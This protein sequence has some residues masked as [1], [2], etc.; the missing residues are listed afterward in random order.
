[1][2]TSGNSQ[3][4]MFCT[5]AHSRIFKRTVKDVLS[6]IPSAEN[7]DKTSWEDIKEHELYSKPINKAHTRAIRHTE[8]GLRSVD[9]H[10]LRIDA[11]LRM[12]LNR[13]ILNGK[14]GL[15][16]KKVHDILDETFFE[17][18]FWTLWSINFFLQPWHS[19]TEF[20]RLLQK[21]LPEMSTHK[22]VR[23]LDRTPFTLYES[24]IIPVTR[25]L[26]DQRVDFRFHAMVTDLKSYSASDPTTISEIVM[27]E[28]GKEMLITVNP[29]DI[30]IVTLGSLSTGM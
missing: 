20:Y 5:Q 18:D 12:D 28:N 13:F 22:D 23:E 17:L 16:S 9:I 21:H 7:P 1:M 19:A 3:R 8:E 26:K 27:L 14:R 10:Q 6:M 25:Y 2:K 30:A 11:N 4:D 24:L 29:I 15:D